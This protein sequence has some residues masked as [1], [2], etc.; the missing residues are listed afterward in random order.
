MRFFIVLISFSLILFSC[1]EKE[2]NPN[3]IFV[4]TDDQR[5]DT[6]GI[7]GNNQVITPNIDKLAKRGA[8]LSHAYNMG[9]WHGAICVASRANS[10][11][12][13]NGNP[14]PTRLAN[15]SRN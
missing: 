3:F 13:S 2:I 1:N 7:I 11:D 5:F 10:S 9:A 15:V 4:Y 8:V 12:R 6:V 14:F